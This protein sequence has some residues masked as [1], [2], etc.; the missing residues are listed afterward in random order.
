VKPRLRWLWRVL[1]R[2]NQVDAEMRDEMRF[3]IDME[4]DRLA[5]EHQ[6]P[7]AEAVR[8]AHVAFG[9]LEKFRQAGRETRGIQFIDAV[10]LDARLGLRML[11]K[12]RGLTLVGGFAMAVAIAVGATF[13]EVISELLDPALPLDD[14]RRIVAVRYESSPGNPERH[15]VR[16]FLDW[17]QVLASIEQLSAFRTVQHNLVASSATPE[18]IKVAE[19]TASGFTVARVPP[20]MGRYL[21]PDDEWEGAAAVVVI[22]HHAWMTRFGGDPGIV[23]RTIALGGVPTTIVGVMPDGFR[24]PV[25]HQFWAPLRTGSTPP[26][27]SD[28][29]ELFVFGRLAPGASMDEAQAELTAAAPQRQPS[30]R[31]DISEPLRPLVIPFTREHLDIADPGLVWVL[32]IAQLLVGALVFVVAVN[33]AILVYA[34]TVTR[35]GEIAIRTALGASRGRIL[36]QLFVEALALATLGAAAGLLV[37][38]VALSRMQTLAMAN[39]AVPWWLDFSLSIYTV[40]Y[41]LMLA[42]FAAAIIGVVP[43]LKATGRSLS[44]NLHELNGRSGTQLGPMWTTLVVTQVAIAVA[45]L[46]VSVHVAMQVMRMEVAGPGF[47]TEKFAVGMIALGETVDGPIEP[48]R[49]RARQLDMIA[50]LQ[51]EPGVTGV[52]FS[53]SV[54]G[55]AG[56]REIEFD[57]GVVSGDVES[58]DVSSMDVAADLFSVYGTRVLAGRAFTPRD[59]SASNAVVVNRTFAERFAPA[60]NVLGLQFRYRRAPRSAG[61]ARRYEIVGVVDDFPAFPPALSVDRE[62]VVYH[63]SEPGQVHPFALSVKFDS[64]VPAGFLDR[65][66]EV[67]AQVDPALQVRRIVALSTFYDQ[68]RAFWRYI[69][70]GATLLTTAVILLSAAGIYALMS[71]TVAQRTREIGIRAALGAAPQRLLISVFGRSARQ[72]ALGLVVGSLLSSTAF[73]V[74]GLD[75]PTAGALLLCVAGIMLVVGLLA[76]VG[77]AR[78]GLRVNASEALR[79]EG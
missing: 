17:R 70:W 3:H 36:G 46:P 55:F 52:T 5:R 72:L 11:L 47:A 43:G 9:G 48:Q 59:T 20:L 24:F 4:A 40:V 18:P 45:V 64:A 16:E 41:A 33:L 51:S 31:P 2:S 77:P 71:F 57:R 68:L 49:L 58:A 75:L 12:H 39:G 60:V 30:V 67:G 38:D 73:L 15:V 63:P 6:L 8:R 74:L 23:G 62:P 53:S 76:A 65:F 7:R 35:I 34:R 19:M 22:G 69:A 66:R 21:L 27:S 79:A 25:D 44:A 29:P 42:A 26:S 28:G 32:R 14:G 61:Q 50:R 78:R 13:F 10:A 1:R 54:P 37:T 56:G